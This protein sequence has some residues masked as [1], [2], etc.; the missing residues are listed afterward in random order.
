MYP[1]IFNPK[2]VCN[3]YL[4][5]KEE[6]DNIIRNNIHPRYPNIA[7]NK[8][9]YLS[10]YLNKENDLL[11]KLKSMNNYNELY[12]FITSI[13]GYGQKTGGLLIRLIIELGISNIEIKNI[14]I[15]RHDIE[16]SYLNGI[17]DNNKLS[18]EEITKLGTIWVESSIK[19]GVNP[20]DIDKYLWT[21]GSRLCAK[22]MC[23]MCPLKINCQTKLKE[24]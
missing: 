18:N 3:N 5:K 8:W 12:T 4:S 19:Y 22:K 20:I 16:I 10:E 14:P 7:L 9:L 1:D 6:L 17:I 15:D 2:Y 11:L 13:K 24:E 23:D 21:I